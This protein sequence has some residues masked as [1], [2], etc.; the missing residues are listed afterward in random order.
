[1]KFNRE[2]TCVSCGSKNLCYGYT[3]TTTNIFVPSGT[4]VVHGY[5]TR[6]YVCLGCGHIGQYIPGSK[7]ERLKQKFSSR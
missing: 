4:F 2:L 1:M 5:R 7:L 6:S 3:G